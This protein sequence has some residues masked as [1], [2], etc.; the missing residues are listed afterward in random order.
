MFNVGFSRVFSR[1]IHR[2]RNG[3]RGTGL[4]GRGNLKWWR[5]WD[6]N[7]GRVFVRFP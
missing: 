6:G 4:Y 7:A 5:C 3:R 2:R 1:K